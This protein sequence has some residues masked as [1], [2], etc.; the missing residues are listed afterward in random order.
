M[1]GEYVRTDD[2][3][4]ESVR[5]A[6]KALSR[7]KGPVLN[8]VMSLRNMDSKD[9]IEKAVMLLTFHGSKG[10]EFKQVI[11]I[12]ADEKTV[13]GGG[14]IMSERRLFYVAVTRAKDA[15]LITYS[16]APSR[17]LMEMGLT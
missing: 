7:M 5:A 4:A 1:S 6:Q 3:N 13:P 11:I 17:F 2:A 16:G 9:N 14:E 8:R 10:L 15:V 12:G